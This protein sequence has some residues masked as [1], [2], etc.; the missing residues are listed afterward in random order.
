MK[1]PCPNCGSLD[2]EFLRGANTKSTWCCDVC[3]D[4]SRKMES[5]DSRIARHIQY[6]PPKNGALGGVFHDA[7]GKGYK[8]KYI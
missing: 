3:A 7:S 6:V 4:I 2:W 8:R 5:L 1:K